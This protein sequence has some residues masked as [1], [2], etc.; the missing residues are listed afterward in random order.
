MRDELV[1]AVERNFTL[2]DEP[3]PEPV[4]FAGTYSDP[5]MG[6]AG[7]VN[8]RFAKQTLTTGERHRWASADGGMHTTIATRHIDAAVP[9][10]QIVYALETASAAGTQ[11][12]FAYKLYDVDPDLSPT[13]AFAELLVRYGVD[14]KCGDRTSRLMA[15][16]IIEGVQGSLGPA[17]TPTGGQFVASGSILPHSPQGPTEVNWGWCL[18]VTAYRAAV[19]RAR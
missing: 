13:E 12:Y 18:D 14:V 8:P 16:E 1:A 2:T 9:H 19:E 6:A 5:I 7:T 11:I 10:L 3:C 17:V 15:V 4:S